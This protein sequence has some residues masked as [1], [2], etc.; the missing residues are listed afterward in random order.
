[1]RNSVG[2]RSAHSVANAPLRQKDA[3][4]K[5][6]GITREPVEDMVLES[7]EGKAEK[8]L[9]KDFAAQVPARS[10]EFGRNKCACETVHNT[11]GGCLT[12]ALLSE[13]APLHQQDFTSKSSGIT[14]E[15]V[16]YLVRQDMSSLQAQQ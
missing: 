10:S 9:A 14:R 15:H 8:L 16:E 5:S 13:H 7:A 2:V 4:G 11:G 6:C 3:A 1:M 12:H